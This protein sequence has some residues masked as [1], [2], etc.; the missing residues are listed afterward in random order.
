VQILVTNDDGIGA[1]GLL[2]LA[3][4]VVAAGHDVVVAAP[5]DDRSGSGAALGRLHV[6]DTI[7]LD[8]VELPGST[9]SPASGWR[10]RP[11]C[12]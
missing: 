3:R 9:A 12:A 8:T 6:D 1:P 2:P 4:A 7:E 11:R 5:R 10:A